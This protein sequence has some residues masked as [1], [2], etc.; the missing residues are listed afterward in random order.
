MQVIYPFYVVLAAIFFVRMLTFEFI[1]SE[2]V[3]LAW[4]FFATAI[5][6]LTWRYSSARN[7]LKLSLAMI[8]IIINLQMFNRS[9]LRLPGALQGPVLILSL[10]AWFTSVR[11][12]IA[13]FVSILLSY[14]LV[15]AAILTHV[16]VEK[17]VESPLDFYI[18]SVA[19]LCCILG[20]VLVPSRLL[21][22]A[23]HDTR[24]KTEEAERALAEL[25]E[26][27]SF[28][29]QAVDSSHRLFGW[30]TPDGMIRFANATA[31]K[32]VGA[33]FDEVVGQAFWDSPWIRHDPSEQ[34]KLKSA[35]AKASAG[36][37]VRLE[38]THRAAD[39]SLR[40]IDFYLIPTFDSSG[41][42]SMLVAEGLDI[43]DELEM[44]SQ[45]EKLQER[46]N[47]SQKMDAGGQLAGGVAHDFN[48]SLAAI[49]GLTELVKVGNLPPEKQREYL[50]IILGQTKRAGELVKKLL[51]FSRKGPKANEAF[52][53]HSLVEDTA[54]LLRRTIDKR[55]RVTVD[56]RA[57]R[58]LIVGDRG[59]IQNVLINMGVNASHA[60]PRGG[61]L[62]FILENARLDEKFCAESS[63]NIRPGEY[64]GIWVRDTGSGMPPEV[65]SRIFE[66]FFTTKEQGKGTG[67]GLSTAYG[68]VQEHRGAIAVESEVGVGSVFRIFLPIS[69]AM[70]AGAAEAEIVQS[71]SESILFVDD[72]EIV[73]IAATGILN[74]VGYK[75]V[76][77][78][79]GLAA[80][81]IL[82]AG[83]ERIDLVVLDMIMPVMGGKDTLQKIRESDPAIPVI[84][85]SGFVR[86]EEMAEL[87]N[88]GVSGFLQK[89]F[90]RTEMADAVKRALSRKG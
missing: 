86:G 58:A 57:S 23:L 52:D 16:A 9:T 42:V 60:M 24:Q 34:E 72:E 12:T 82:R 90:S 75:V 89:P 67:L 49:T 51:V 65:L 84:I 48:N 63:F 64:L 10:A 66:P 80:V 31:L 62:S 13:L 44:L 17:P 7:A 56:N 59:M 71:G 50:D 88:L 43:T 28:S 38:T 39:G 26:S 74:S 21:R 79:N 70:A 54:S 78:E 15:T 8:W 29:I 46:L 18:R 6:G 20:T 47:Q 53:A 33:G 27:R 3:T 61:E 35:I 11:I 81:E 41:K 1:A 40:K 55:I 37:S 77:A 45:K 36:T 22:Q 32:M 68:T 2:A 85:T 69:E 4:I 76:A 14:T 19:S 5:T 30:L 83:R 87:G 73:R 25:R